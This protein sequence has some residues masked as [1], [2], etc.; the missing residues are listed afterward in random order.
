MKRYLIVLILLMLGPMIYFASAEEGL[1]P[2]WHNMASL[3]GEGIKRSDFKI[4]EEIK[5]LYDVDLLNRYDRRWG[6][7]LYQYVEQM[8]INGNDTVNGL[9]ISRFGINNFIFWNSSDTTQ[10]Y[11]L[12]KTGFRQNNRYYF[13]HRNPEDL[14]VVK[15]LSDNTIDTQL[16]EQYWTPAF[17]RFSCTAFAIKLIFK[18]GL[19]DEAAVLKLYDPHIDEYHSDYT[20]QE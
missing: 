19:I 16:P 2:V 7:L 9:I 11:R 15:M 1:R 5:Q 12:Q 20:G 4:C 3:K 8:R 6:M 10:F 17:G 13:S 14:D 18:D